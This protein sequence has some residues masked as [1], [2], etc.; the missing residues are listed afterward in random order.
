M[1]EPGKEV[2]HH[3]VINGFQYI[4]SFQ[5]LFSN[6][7]GMITFMNQ[8]MVPRLISWR[9]RFCYSFIPFIRRL[10]VLIDI[11][12]YTAIVEKAMVN[13][14]TYGEFNLCNIRYISH[15]LNIM[16]SLNKLLTSKHLYSVQRMVYK[17]LLDCTASAGTV[18]IKGIV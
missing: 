4:I 16:A 15:S 6:I 2:F 7:C 8:H 13:Q 5:I 18:Y 14:F 1:F 9:A 12:Y 11:N 10:E 17:C 3:G